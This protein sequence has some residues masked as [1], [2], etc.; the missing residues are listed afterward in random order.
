MIVLFQSLNPGKPS[1]GI[2]HHTYLPHWIAIPLLVLLIIG[3]V[4]PTLAKRPLVPSLWLC[5]IIS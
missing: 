5:I 2:P 3:A 1:F 4:I